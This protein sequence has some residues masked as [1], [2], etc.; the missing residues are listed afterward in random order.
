MPQTI[1][2]NLDIRFPL[3][4]QVGDS[5]KD[6]IKSLEDELERVKQVLRQWVNVQLRPVIGVGGT[7][8]PAIIQHP[9]DTTTS[10][11]LVPTGGVVITSHGN[12]VGNWP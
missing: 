2:D 10:I 7:L 8:K 11:K 4:K 5:D 1:T 12:P 9:S 6:R 3:I